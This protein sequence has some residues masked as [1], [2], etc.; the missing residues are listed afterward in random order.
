MIP[1]ESY[2]P[3]AIIETL[4]NSLPTFYTLSVLQSVVHGGEIYY[5]ASHLLIAP[6]AAQNTYILD[7]SHELIQILMDSL[8]TIR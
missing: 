4:I 6:F 8:S 2:M 7:R 1:M 5:E 3:D